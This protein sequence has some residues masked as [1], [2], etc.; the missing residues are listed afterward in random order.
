MEMVVCDF[1]GRMDVEFK[2]LRGLGV[3]R[4]ILRL[5]I[6]RRHDALR[7]FAVKVDPLLAG[8]LSGIEHSGKPCLRVLGSRAF[9]PAALRQV[10]A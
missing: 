2:I 8:G 9:P 4:R 7:L 3:V 6:E 10:Q 5:R 1:P